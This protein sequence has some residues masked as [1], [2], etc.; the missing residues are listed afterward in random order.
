MTHSIISLGKAFPLDS[1]QRAAVSP[2]GSVGASKCLRPFEVA[3]GDPHL[4]TL[5]PGKLSSR[6]AHP[7]FS[8]GHFDP[9]ILLRV[10]SGCPLG[11]LIF[12][13]L[14]ALQVESSGHFDHLIFT[15]WGVTCYRKTEVFKM[16]TSVA[17]L[18]L[19]SSSQS[20]NLIQQGLRIKLRKA[21]LDFR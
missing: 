13:D 11:N 17:S 8:V 19:K 10:E 3:T 2:V 18:Q 20:G 16:I 15:E 4:C 9:L 5:A 21:E 7:A 6:T 14:E 12:N 1:L